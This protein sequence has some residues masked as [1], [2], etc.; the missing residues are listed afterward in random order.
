V[1]LT[2]VACLGGNVIVEHRSSNLYPLTILL[3]ELQGRIE[4][5]DITAVEFRC[6]HCHHA[7]IR[8][9]DD[10]LKIPIS[11]GNCGSHWQDDHDVETLQRFLRY[12]T[13]YGAK[14]SP[15]SLRLH[16]QQLKEIAAAR[17]E[18]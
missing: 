18:L 13:S 15:Y 5:Q 8:R 11:C 12:I 14:D 10:S 16:V 7:S 17:S 9:L 1:R 6:K 2:K 3:T 4:P